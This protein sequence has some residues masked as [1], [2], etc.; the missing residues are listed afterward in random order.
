MNEEI[1]WEAVVAKPP[2][3]KLYRYSADTKWLHASI[4]DQVLYLS[5]PPTFNDPFDCQIHCHFSGD[6]HQASAVTRKILTGSKKMRIEPPKKRLRAF[7]RAIGAAK[8][9]GL[10]RADQ[11]EEKLRK[12]I[13][14]DGVTCFSE[15]P[16]SILMWSHYA[17]KHTGVCLEFDTK[18]ESWIAESRQVQYTQ[19]CPLLSFLEQDWDRTFTKLILTKSKAW[20][21][22]K[23]WRFFSA[24]PPYNRRRAFPPNALTG[25]IFGARMK[26]DRKAE[27]A[28]KIYAMPFAPTLSELIISK[29]EFKLVQRPYLA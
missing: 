24:A 9:G 7:S 26:P 15:D 2:P 4:F 10:Y 1:D 13:S 14:D 27:L 3:K 28:R 23:E 25:V 6:Q 29:D 22:E 17:D 11:L 8:N 21:H 19:N 20:E 5:S 16:L 18:V 12:R